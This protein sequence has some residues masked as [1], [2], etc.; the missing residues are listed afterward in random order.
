MANQVVNTFGFDRASDTSSYWRTRI[1][2][3]TG[4]L[5]SVAPAPDHLMMSSYTNPLGYNT[6][7]NTAA[8]SYYGAVETLQ[9]IDGYYQ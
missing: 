8:T 9:F 1:N 6:G 3:P 7:V 2:G 4:Y 5:T